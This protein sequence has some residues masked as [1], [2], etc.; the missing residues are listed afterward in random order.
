MEN[1]KV[2]IMGIA[3]KHRVRLRKLRIGN[4][5]SYVVEASVVIPIF[6]LAVMML[7][8][9]LPIISACEGIAYSAAEEMRKEMALSA[10]RS[11]PAALPV[12]AEIR[13]K[14]ENPDASGIRVTSYRYRYQADGTE[15][16]IRLKVRAAFRKGNSL[17]LY[18]NVRFTCAI[19]GRAFTGAYYHEE[20]NGAGDETVYIFPQ[21]GYSYHNAGCTF[22]RKGCRQVYLTNDLKKRLRACPNC[23]AAE[24]AIGSP[25][26][27]FQY[28]E[29]YHTAQCSSVEHYYR[30][31]RKSEAV[32]DGYKPCGK[33]GG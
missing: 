15:D 18:G 16:L 2:Q 12:K 14:K 19:R 7:I 3:R 25:V 28:G 29:A 22:V 8:G 9:I 24:A 33:C 32:R 1:S 17:G 5:G 27:T 4:T 30:A 20:E 21:R 6:V 11:N 23:H 31:V 26:F 13:M 10:F